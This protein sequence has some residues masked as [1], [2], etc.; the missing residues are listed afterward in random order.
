MGLAHWPSAQRRLDATGAQVVLCGHDHQEGAGQLP[1]G[2]VVSTASTLS[3]RTRGKRPSVF[4]V[5]RLDRDAVQV[6]HWRWDR[7][8]DEFRASDSHTFARA[9]ERHGV[10]GAG[11]DA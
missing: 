1:R 6:E 8:A 9:G 7:A 3:D 4:N 2:T 11:R 10:V 5:V